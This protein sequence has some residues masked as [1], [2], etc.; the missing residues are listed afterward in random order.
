[1]TFGTCA[2]GYLSGEIPKLAHEIRAGYNTEDASA[3]SDCRVEFTLNLSWNSPQN[4]SAARC[5]ANP[6]REC[7]AALFRIAHREAFPHSTFDTSSI[8]SGD[9][10]AICD[11]FRDYTETALRA[12]L[13][14]YEWSGRNVRAFSEAG[15]EFGFHSRL[16][17]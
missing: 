9:S 1:M 13:D 15:T 12:E 5:R 17:D 16:Q 8:E 11:A 10:H 4:A 6:L 14:Q 7:I 2:R 3:A